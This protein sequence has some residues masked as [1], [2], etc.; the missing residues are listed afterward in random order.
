LYSFLG[1]LV[2]LYPVYAV[3]FADTG[4]STA[5]IS[6]LFVIWSV[7][8]LALE[9][10]S[11]VL[12]DLVPRR[13]LLVAGPLLAAI[14]YALWVAIPSFASFAAGF[15]LWGAHSALQSGALEALVYEELDRH[16]M[17]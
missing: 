7:A 13:S 1:D 6:A 12:A 11:G 9:I 17:A 4:L 3:L 14:G 2:L 16:G 8:S 15:V 5:Q 10:P